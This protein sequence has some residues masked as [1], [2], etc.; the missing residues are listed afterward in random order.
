[1][2]WR[3]MTAVI[4]ISIN[5]ITLLVFNRYQQKT[6]SYAPDI[7]WFVMLVLGIGIA[8]AGYIYGLLDQNW[9]FILSGFHIGFILSIRLIIGKEAER[10]VVKDM[11]EDEKVE[12]RE[13][14]FDYK[15]SKKD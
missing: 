6:S 3:M 15:D 10:E 2:L 7:L 1:M 9:L 11:T 14:L 4:L 5:I 12:W 13:S 8:S